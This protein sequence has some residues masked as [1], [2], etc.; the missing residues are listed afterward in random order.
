MVVV[1]WICYNFAGRSLKKVARHIGSV[2]SH[3]ADFR[4][5]CGINSCPLVYTKFPSFKRH[6]FRHHKSE[7][8]QSEVNISIPSL[9]QGDIDSDVLQLDSSDDVEEDD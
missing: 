6:L 2:H 4:L 9:N 8:G 5:V 7:L 1:C 3:E